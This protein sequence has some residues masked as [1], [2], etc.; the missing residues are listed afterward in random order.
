MHVTVLIPAR[1]TSQYIGEA[2]LSVFRQ[3]HHDYDILVVDDGS[4]DDTA[5][6]VEREMH[7][8]RALSLLRLPRPLGVAGATAAG[9]AQAQGPVVTILDSDDRLLPTALEL[10]VK[11]FENPAVGYVWTEFVCSTGKPGWSHA[12]PSGM[13]LWTALVHRGWWKA[14]HQR[15][16]AL[17]W[18]RRSR[19]LDAR[20]RASSDFQLALVLAATGCRC[21][22][23]RKATYWYRERRAGQLSNDT[24]YQKRCV[25]EMRAAAK[26]WPTHRAKVRA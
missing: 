2:M 18:Y 19:G 7:S 3:S 15:F 26:R 8:E 16:V 24:T 25:K 9:I 17:P 13:D 20:W 5:A 4:R 12:L 10:G 22:H 21:V 6:R 11:P 1:D 23:V 14:S